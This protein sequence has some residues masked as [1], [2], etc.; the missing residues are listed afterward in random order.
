MSLEKV[1]SAIIPNLG[2]GELTALF[3]NGIYQPTKFL[4]DTSYGFRVMSQTKFKM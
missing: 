3:I 1:Q 2:N 4:V